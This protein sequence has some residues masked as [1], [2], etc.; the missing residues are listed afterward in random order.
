MHMILQNTYNYLSEE[1]LV[2]FLL[3]LQ[4]RLCMILIIADCTIIV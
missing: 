4:S 2:Q 3:I 1:F